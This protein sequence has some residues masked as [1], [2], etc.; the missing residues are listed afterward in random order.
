MAA[1]GV[2]LEAVEVGAEYLE[3]KGR[4]DEESMDARS[5][6]EDGWD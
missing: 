6:D 3:G 5:G 4:E 1:E 2:L